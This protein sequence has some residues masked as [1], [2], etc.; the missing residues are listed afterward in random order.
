MKGENYMYTLNKIILASL[1]LFLLM[2]EPSLAVKISLSSS[3][4]DGSIGVSSTYR[5]SESASLKSDST[6]DGS[7]IFQN[8]Q[9][10]GNRNNALTQSIGG[11]SYSSENTIQSSGPLHISAFIAASPES[12]TVWQSVSSTGDIYTK[13]QG[14]QGN[15]FAEQKTEVIDG[16]LSST[17]S[18]TIAAGTA[19]GQKAEMGGSLCRVGSNAISNNNVMTVDG[20]FYKVDDIKTELGASSSGMAKTEGEVAAY[21]DKCLTESILKQIT[22]KH[23]GLAFNTFYLADKDSDGDPTDFKGSVSIDAA[24]M[25]RRAYENPR[26][27]PQGGPSA[28]SQT[29]YGARMGNFWGFLPTG[30]SFDRDNFGYDYYGPY[31]RWNVADSPIQLY[32]RTDSDFYST[33]LDPTAVCNAIATAANVW[34]DATSRNLFTDSNTVIRDPTIP[35]DK[36]DGKVVNSFSYWDN[37]LPG[38]GGISAALSYNWYKIDPATDGYHQITDSEIR[39]NTYFSLTTSNIA[40]YAVHELGHTLGLADLYQPWKPDAYRVNNQV[41]IMNQGDHPLWLGNGDRMGIW[42]LYGR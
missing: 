27:E 1:F 12:A 30:N 33:G 18:L 39:Y 41:Q 21:G 14:S 26:G 3:D 15:D 10:S 16:S 24:N 37:E 32:L 40:D 42:N 36:D 6:L 20:K 2:T 34:D 38:V 19:V 7:K 28:G 9:L 11:G 5:L 13:L 8:N 23:V 22:S 4:G 29:T 31:E 35:K 25:D 17:Q